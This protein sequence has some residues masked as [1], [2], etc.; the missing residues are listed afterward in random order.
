[1]QRTSVHGHPETAQPIC[2]WSGGAK[3]HCY[4]GTGPSGNQELHRQAQP[5]TQLDLVHHRRT[6]F[7]RQRA[8]AGQPA[9]SRPRCANTMPGCR[10]ACRMAGAP[11][12]PR[13]WQDG[14]TPMPDSRQPRWCRSARNPCRWHP[15]YRRF[16][17]AQNADRMKRRSRIGCG[18]RRCNVFTRESR[19][20]IRC[21]RLPNRN[22]PLQ[23]QNALGQLSHRWPG[24]SQLV[25]VQMPLRLVDYVVVHELRI[26]CN[27][28]STAL[29]KPSRASFGLPGAGPK[30]G[31]R[32]T[33][34]AGGSGGDAMPPMRTS[35]R[36]S[37][38]HA[39]RHPF[40]RPVG[41][42]GYRPAT[43]RNPNPK[44]SLPA[45]A[46][47]PAGP[48]RP[49]CRGLPART[50]FSYKRRTECRSRPACRIADEHGTP[51]FAARAADRRL[52]RI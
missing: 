36:P 14:E 5:A 38:H 19:T 43:C 17:L 47:A 39:H 25:L 27:E 9:Q 24:S 15:V 48:R 22:P 20:S 32:V 40:C 18:G 46:G 16:G 52:A 11:P 50:Y 1:M 28:P 4:R 42:C 12:A 34:Y 30:S 44:P 35:I 21:L 33:V 23:R 31:P 7:A 51:C 2:R 26:S 45:R 13:L 6:R 29:G 8:V 41:A 3:R 37:R 49:E 10:K